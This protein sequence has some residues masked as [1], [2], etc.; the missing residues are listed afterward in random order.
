[1]TALVALLLLQ[2]LVEQAD[3][4]FRAGDLERAAALAAKAVESRTGVVHAHMILGVIAAQRQQWVAANRHFSTV[5][6]LSPADPNGHFYLGQAKLYQKQWDAALRDFA[7]AEE[8]GFADSERLAV[9]MAFAETEL[10]RPQEALDRLRRLPAGGSAHFHAVT[11]FALAALHQYP[12]ALEAIA[13][14]R[15]REPA[16][17]EHVHFLISTLIASDQMQTALREAITAQAR[18]PDHADI[19]FL[20]VLASYYVPESPLGPLA[21]RNLQE[22]EPAG[23]PRVLLAQGL[24]HR[25]RGEG[26]EALA[27]F[28]KAAARGVP[29]SHLLLAILHKEHGDLETAAREF[30]EAERLNPRNGQVMLEMGKL[31]LAR[32]DT[33]EAVTRLEAAVTLMPAS[34]AAHYQLSLALTRAGR[35]EEA[36]RHLQLS[37]EL[38]RRQ[39]EMAGK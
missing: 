20:F 8:R 11:A 15:E 31:A 35:K 26:E 25:K 28:Q 30:R 12:E 13:Q 33:T 37:R 3:Q 18:F 5:V 21:L 10:G 9:E 4:A 32:S 7:K 29:D 6:R 17:P 14:A 16:N 22:C 34:S 2:S 38:D 27:A 19:Q 23:S 24:L 36:T 39:A 1:M